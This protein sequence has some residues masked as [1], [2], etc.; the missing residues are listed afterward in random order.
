[1]LT[2]HYKG[3]GHQIQADFTVDLPQISA[4][5]HLILSHFLILSL[6]HPVKL[7]H[8]GCFKHF[9]KTLPHL[10]FNPKE[11]ISNET[12]IHT[13]PGRTTAG[14]VPTR[15]KT[16]RSATI[17]HNARTLHA[18]PRPQRPLRLRPEIPCDGS[19]GS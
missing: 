7:F 10:K 1:M 15:N 12:T 14:Y 18:I 3:S 9:V 6:D 8:R 4:N 13:L 16:T 19:D 5:N 11:D 2:L 17:R